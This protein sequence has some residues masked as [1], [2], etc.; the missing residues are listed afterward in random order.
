MTKLAIAANPGRFLR[1]IVLVL[2]VF[3]VVGLALTALFG[4][5]EPN[6]TLLLLS[7]GL[8]LAAATAVFAHLSVSRALTARQKRI[9]LRQLTGRRCAWAFGEYL[10]CDDLGAAATRFADAALAP[11]RAGQQLPP[12]GGTP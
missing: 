2:V 12:S 4:F 8:L 9:W 10:S 7:S 1:V 5:E 6:N 3:G 11:G